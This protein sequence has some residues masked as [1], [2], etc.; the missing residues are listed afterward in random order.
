[1]VLRSRR[2]GDTIRLLG[3]TKTLKKLFID[4]KI[5]AAE[6]DTIPVLA[7][8][9]GVLAVIGIGGNLDRLSG[10]GMVRIQI[11]YL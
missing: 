6:R 1:M 4:E 10:D 2:A 8:E 3:G 5:P 11:E 9:A 7:D